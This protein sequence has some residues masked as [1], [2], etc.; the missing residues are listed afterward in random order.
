MKTDRLFG[1]VHCLLNGKTT[2]G[3]LA[4]RFGVSKRTILRDLETL[5]LAGVPVC[6]ASGNGGGVSVLDGYVLDKTA[7]SE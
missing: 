7:L 2:T 5:S 4:E 3:E 1:I 6:T